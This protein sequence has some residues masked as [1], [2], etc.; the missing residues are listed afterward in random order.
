M[1][2]ITRDQAIAT[3]PT[4]ARGVSSVAGGIGFAMLAFFSFTTMDAVLK[5]LS[6]GYPLHQIVFFNAAFALGPIGI[7]IATHGGRRAIAT[8]RPW[9][10][11]ARGAISVVGMYGGIYA[12]SLLPMTDVYAILFAAPIVITALSVP[13]LGEQVGWRRW[14][15]VVV[16]FIG[17]VIMLRPAD[18]F[19]NI[20]TFAALLA[21]MAFSVSIILVRRFGANEPVAMFSVSQMLPLAAW[22]GLLTLFDFVPPTP[23]DLAFSAL[24]GTVGGMASLLMVQAIRRTPAAILAPFQ[25]SQMIWGTVIGWLLWQDLPDEWILIGGGLVIASGLYI[26]HRET[27]RGLHRR[28][29]A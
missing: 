6:A 26:L 2:V 16:G 23:T 15:A 8:H 19:L 7:F 1:A 11:V 9:L 4:D 27:V 22:F 25:Y 14:S 17:V 10:H 3:P 5:W 28:K 13:L 20:G 18:D 12:F 29:A 21:M 24:G